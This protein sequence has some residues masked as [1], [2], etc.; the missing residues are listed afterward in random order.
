MISNRCDTRDQHQR[1]FAARRSVGM[2]VVSAVKIQKLTFDFHGDVMSCSPVN[3]T[4]KPSPICWP[5]AEDIEAVPLAQVWQK[6]S[7]R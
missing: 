4:S 6:L 7:P 3:P 2:G 1:F 5:M